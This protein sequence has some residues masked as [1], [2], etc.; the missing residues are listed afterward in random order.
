VLVPALEAV[1]RIADGAAGSLDDLAQVA[2]IMAATQLPRLTAALWAQASAFSA[3]GLAAGAYSLAVKGLSAAM[4]LV[5]GPLGIAAAAL[6]A[7]AI[8]F[9]NSR[10]DGELLAETLGKITTAQD[11]LNDATET[12]YTDMSQKALEAMTL[13]A[14]AALTSVRDAL[15]AAQEEMSDASFTTNFFGMSLMET[16]R[17]AEAR[18]EVERLAGLLIEAEA[19]MS[20]VDHAASNFAIRMGEGGEAVDAVTSGVVEL[21]EEQQKAL[22]TSNDLIQTYQNRADLARA[23]MQYG[24]DSAEY[25]QQQLNQERQ[26]AFAKIEALDISARQKAIA[27][28]AYDQMVMTEAAAQGWS[29][30][31]VG[32]NGQLS[33]AYDWLVDISETQPGAS[34][35]DT[36]ISKAASLAATLWDAVAANNSLSVGEAEGMTTGTP[37][38]EQ[39]MYGSSLGLDL[40]P[41]DGKKSSGGGGGG[42]SDGFEDK[43]E[44]LTEQFQTERELADQWYEE[45]MEIL[46]DR[47]AMEILGAEGHAEALL[48]IEEE[49]AARIAEID[50]A[51]YQRRM[52]DAANLFGQLANIASVGGKKTAVAVATFQAIEGTIN[53][54]GA[55][56]KALNTPGLSVAGRFAAYAAVLGAGLK[57]V[58]SIKAAMGGGGGGSGS[59]G[60]SGSSYEATPE[61]TQAPRIVRLDVQGEGIFADMLRESGQAIVDAI[62]NE[63]DYGGTTIV[64]G[65]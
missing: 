59:G 42:G 64:M 41:P 27:R 57:G 38:Y 28:E 5:G 29:V 49:K 2:A 15:A 44:R 34:W 61:P 36:A 30:E 31:M 7:I 50:A 63:G 1:I 51:A 25:L 19:R 48:A 33:T 24:K 6:A 65:R 23:E 13:Q 9:A 47:R 35:L 18:A 46:E 39:G 54:Y 14:E 12:Y 40:L 53:A 3:A 58:A 10:R 26:I 32:V 20:A 55:A 45:S 56:I 22:S 60:S 8:G 52:S 21:N 17:M 43:L 62:T 16:E 37:L 11:A 4:A